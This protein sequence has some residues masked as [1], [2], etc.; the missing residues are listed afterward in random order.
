MNNPWLV[1]TSI[2]APNEALRLFA[3]GCGMHDYRFVVIGDSK[4]PD[5]FELDGCDFWS[6]D[7]QSKSDLAYAKLCPT[8]HY[9]RKNLG[10]LMR[11]E[12]KPR[13]FGTLTMTTCHGRLFGRPRKEFSTSRHSRKKDGS[14]FTAYSRR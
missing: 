5:S 14:T 3:N 11:S 9:A 13:S 6:L 10:Y 7:R 1:I 8:K 2:S 12:S 4:S